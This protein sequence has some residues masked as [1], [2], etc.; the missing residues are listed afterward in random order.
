MAA[1]DTLNEA[2][3]GLT[4]EQLQ[5][6]KAKAWSIVRKQVNKGQSPSA[7][8]AKEIV[9]RA[10]PTK[11]ASTAPEEIDDEPDVPSGTDEPD[12][13]EAEG[14]PDLALDDSSCG[15]LSMVMSRDA[16]VGAFSIEDKREEKIHFEVDG[17]R[18]SGPGTPCVLAISATVDCTFSLHRDYV[19][20]IR[21]I[22][23]CPESHCNNLLLHMRVTGH[24][25]T[26]EAKDQ[27][28]SLMVRVP[29]KLE[30]EQDEQ[31]DQAA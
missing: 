25:L 18:M 13:S 1:V 10:L 17:R 31:D 7:T 23:S 15:V 12:N 29:A 30:L 8:E 21:S 24:Y 9:Q 16:L 27:N 5:N 2:A 19:L 14:Q 11:T 22:L 20:G 4:E 28:C 3:D 6:A 26:I